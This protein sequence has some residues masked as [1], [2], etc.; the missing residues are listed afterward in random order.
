MQ[1]IFGIIIG[2]ILLGVMVVV[3]EFGHARQAHRSGVVVEEFAVGFPPRIW[4]KKLKNGILF[5]INSVPL[6]GYTKLQGEY[7]AADKIGDYG[8]ATFW[9]K[10]KI[11][12]AGIVANWLLAA[13][14]LTIL[15]VTGLPVVLP[16]QLTVPGDT[17]MVRQPVEIVSITKGQAAEKAGLL[18]GDTIIRF[19]GQ[20]VPTV[21]GLISAIKKN[22][23]RNV[24][25]IY[26][27]SGTEYSTKVNLGH[28]ADG[29]FL[30]AG[31]GQRELIKA[32]WS[33]PIVGVATTM[34]FTGATIQG[35]GGLIKNIATSGI[36]SVSGEVAGPIGILGT[37]FPAAAQSGLTQLVYLTA[38][39]SL[40]LAVMNLLPIPGLDGGRWLTMALFKL[41]KWKLTEKREEKIQ[42]VGFLLLMILVI[43][44]TISDV[45][46]LF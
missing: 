42:T 4:S 46:K 28:G 23:G 43:L 37:M 16:N 29:H 3:H 38:I 44:V 34:Q 1:L 19:A 26:N 13:I 2:V 15:A 7:D 39:I 8:R 9:Q 22:E 24:S 27:R 40:S 32:T 30:G 31:L 12:L 18:N 10:T 14:L 17:T 11:L 20:Q 36:G 6:G 21:D 41:F 33:A 5:T 35:I 45:A 25:V